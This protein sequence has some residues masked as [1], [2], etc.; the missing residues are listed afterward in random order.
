[1]RDEIPAF[2]LA[3]GRKFVAGRRFIFAEARKYFAVGGK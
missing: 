2:K 3:I 1:L